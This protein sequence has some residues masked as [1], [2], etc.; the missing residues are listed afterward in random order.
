MIVNGTEVVLVELRG[1]GWYSGKVESHSA[2]FPVD[3]FDK[4]FDQFEG[5]IPY[6]YELD[7]KNSEV[8]GELI[9]HEN[10][11]DIAKAFIRKIEPYLIYDVL[12][13]V[14]V[15]EG[16]KPLADQIW[17]FNEKLHTERK[18]VTTVIIGD[19]KIEF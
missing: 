19:N 4:Y 11:V 2:F 6:F 13:D 18:V 7:G 16:E 15:D 3:L 9:V 17:E 8:E 12:A 1:E 10:E 14:E 5:Y